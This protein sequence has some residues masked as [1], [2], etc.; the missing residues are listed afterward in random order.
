VRVDLAVIGPMARNAADL[1]LGLSVVAGPDELMEGIGYKLALQ[2]PRHDK[3]ADFRVLV[4]AG[5]RCARLQRISLRRSTGSPIASRNSAAPCCA[6]AQNCP[7]W[8]ARR[9]IM[10]SCWRRFS[11]PIRRPKSGC[12]A[13]LPHQR[14]PPMI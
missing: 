6:R 11:V 2:P 3:L 14:C 4:V 12:A 1:A 13:R 8:R 9:A 7:T 10:S 5:A